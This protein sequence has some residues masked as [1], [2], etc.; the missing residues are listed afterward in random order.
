[1]FQVTVYYCN[2]SVQLKCQ[3]AIKWHIVVVMNKVIYVSLLIL[4]VCTG[5]A[6]YMETMCFFILELD[7][8]KASLGC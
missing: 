1:M 3:C 8:G 6:G 7:S 4:N 2:E 5:R